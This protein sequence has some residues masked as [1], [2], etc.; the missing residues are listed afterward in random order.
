MR[1]GG[2][3]GPRRRGVTSRQLTTAPSARRRSPAIGS[4]RSEPAARSAARSAPSASVAIAQVASPPPISSIR[5]VGTP[6]HDRSASARSKT[7]MSSRYVSPSQTSRLK[8]PSASCRPPLV[9]ARPSSRSSC[10]AASAGS[11]TAITRWSMPRN[12][13]VSVAAPAEA[14]GLPLDPRVPH[15]LEA[16]PPPCSYHDRSVVRGARATCSRPSRTTARNASTS[17]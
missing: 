12:T 10:T 4:P 5:T 17:T 7:P 1:K 14:S 8:V 15:P 2:S 13:Q 11:A 3:D 9:A 16:P 6:I